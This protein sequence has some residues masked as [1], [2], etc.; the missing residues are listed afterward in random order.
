MGPNPYLEKIQCVLHVSTWDTPPWLGVGVG[1]A[2]RSINHPRVLC[3]G[4]HGWLPSELHQEPVILDPSLP[5]AF[6]VSKL[7][8][9]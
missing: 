7:C 3:L 8:G 9:L 5:R 4:T 1:L 6:T 2:L